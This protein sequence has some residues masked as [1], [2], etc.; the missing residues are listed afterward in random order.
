MA[1]P[2][3]RSR[4]IWLMVGS[5]IIAVLAAPEFLAVIPVTWM[6]YVSATVAVLGITLRFLTKEGIKWH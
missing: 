4:T 3:W 5:L 1:K 2:Y 6:P